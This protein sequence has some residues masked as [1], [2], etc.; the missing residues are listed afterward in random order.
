[1]SLRAVQPAEAAT[2][3]LETLGLDPS[4]TQLMGEE[5]L[6]ATIRRAASFICPTTPGAL[7]REVSDA[8]TGLPTVDETVRGRAEECVLTLRRYGDLLELAT[9][10]ENRR[11]RLY[12][13]PPS[14][15]PTGDGCL[16]VGIRPE[17]AP[18]G[19]TG[20]MERIT[21][22]GHRRSVA[23]CDGEVESLL[24]EDGLTEV[25]IAQWLQVPREVSSESFVQSFRARLLASGQVT[26]LEDLRVIDPSTSVRFYVGRWRDLRS[27]DNGE[28]VARRPQAFGAD[29][30]CVVAVTTGQV[31]HAVDL[32]LD[33]LN[34]SGADQALRLQAALDNLAGTP[35]LVSLGGDPEQPTRTLDLFSPVPTWCQRKLDVVATPEERSRGALM[36][37]RVPSGALVDTLGFLEKMLWLVCTD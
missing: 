5:A 22:Q 24:A 30:W 23:V 21:N 19:G 11:R 29:L 20:L 34:A 9:E 28:F 26:G 1:V 31:T 12:L 25:S 13:G 10:P 4:D 8:L 2:L 14:F 32:P 35:Q 18:I 7:A 17:G 16:I 37:Y 36:S 27:D 15:V 3:T 33:D 6:C